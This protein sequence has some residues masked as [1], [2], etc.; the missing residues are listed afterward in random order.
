MIVRVMGEGQ[1]Q[2]D[3]SLTGRLNELDAATA[4]AV[5]AGDQTALHAS[6]EAL[7]AAVRDNGERLADDYL[8][9]SDAVIPPADLSLEEAKELLHGEGLVPDIV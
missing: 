3:D 9:A 8:G 2:V 1:W 5:E 6:L 7:A 4:R